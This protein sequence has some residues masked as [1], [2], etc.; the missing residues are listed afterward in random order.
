[1]QTIV[2]R[3]ESKN[4]RYEIEILNKVNVGPYVETEKNVSIGNKIDGSDGFNSNSSHPTPTND[5]KLSRIWSD[6]KDKQLWVFCFSDLESLYKWFSETDKIEDINK[7]L[8]IGV[9][10][11]DEYYDYHKGSFQSTMKACNSR[12]IKTLKIR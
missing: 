8:R 5:M 4:E 2:Y 7:Y 10:E 12:L 3:L 11:V 6:I 9:Y 1:M